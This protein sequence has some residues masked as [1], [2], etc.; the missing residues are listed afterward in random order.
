MEGRKE[1]KSEEI[2]GKAIRSFAAEERRGKRIRSGAIP[3]I[4]L[5]IFSF[6]FYFFNFYVSL[7]IKFF[8]IF[9]LVNS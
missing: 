7:F 5:T 4:C 6:S 2:K 8:L 9:F 1:E 3:H